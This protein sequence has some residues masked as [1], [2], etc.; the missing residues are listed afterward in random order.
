MGSVALMTAL[1]AVTPVLLATTLL[2]VARWPA[3]RAMP[4]C[5]LVTAI[6]AVF[7]WRVPSVYAAAAGAE[8][9]A[10]T[11]S[12]LLILFGALFLV[13]QL[14]EVGAVDSIHR[15]LC[16]LSPDSRV[17]VLLVAWLLGSFFEG[18]SGFGAPPAIT[19]PLLVA[20]GIAPIP[21]VVLALVGD[22]VAV[23]F[24]AVGTPMLVGMGRGL[25]GAPGAIPAVDEIARRLSVADLVTGTLVP[26][27]LVLTF[28]VM[29]KGRAGIAPGLRAAPFALTIGLVH[30]GTTALIAFGLGPELPSIIGPLVGML[31]AIGL[32]RRGW[33]VP[34]DNWTIE[35]S[36]PTP[37]APSVAAPPTASGTST[38][39]KP[40]PKI[41]L[42]LLPYGL[43]IGLLM[44]TRARSLGIGETLSHVSV[45]WQNVGNT[46]INATFEPLYSPG[47]LFVVVA[48]LVPALF[49]SPTSSLPR[50][51]KVAWRKLGAATLPLL[52]AIVTV[53]LFVHS[54]VNTSGF[55]AM[56][57]VL[58]RSAARFSGEFWPV[59]AP[60]VGALGS[61]IAGSATFSNLLFASLQ[62][63]VA[64]LH[65]LDSVDILA[66]QGMGA[67]A[68]NMTCIHNVVAASA[69]VGLS[70][71]E[72]DVM[73][74]AA[75][76]M[77]VY[78]VSAS[79]L[80]WLRLP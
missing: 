66:L 6:C 24:G 1:I 45:G 62:Q 47:A 38:A 31:T 53:R 58:G 11:I 18:A 61:F 60:W 39:T 19:A 78:L 33:L 50:S 73:R 75:P 26:A 25:I 55:E 3:S 51:A 16:R 59:V 42:A 49:K 27:C 67:A 20:L 77:V 80:G 72:G 71:A 34:R 5:A 64:T 17:Q 10:I 44:V 65:Q 22:S 21:S 79:V 30:L 36:S 8:A 32:L 4:A 70:R 57:L 15:W 52:A 23:S 43:L 9:L 56:P 68:G 76:A 41:G 37:L 28:T 46:G 63:S 48:L 12:V 40:P 14:R 74:R 54:E 69:V 7:Y 13:E 29:M 2:V 35:R